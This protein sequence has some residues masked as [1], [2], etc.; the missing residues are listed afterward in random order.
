MKDES[1]DRFLKAELPKLPR[2]MSWKQVTAFVSN[3]LFPISE[4]SVRRWPLQVRRINGRG[5]LD[6]REALTH[7]WG[8]YSGDDRRRWFRRRDESTDDIS[9]SATPNSQISKF[10]KGEA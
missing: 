8:L 10:Q 5:T 7:A 3:K 1:L 4:G 9:V 6:S 2:R